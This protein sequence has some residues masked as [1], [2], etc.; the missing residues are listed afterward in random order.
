MAEFGFRCRCRARSPRRSSATLQVGALSD[1]A[2]TVVSNGVQLLAAVLA[3]AGCAVASF[4]AEGQRRRAWL[5]LKEGTGSWAAGQVVWS[6]YE[7]W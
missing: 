2:V 1:F 4:R 5:W 6:F 7:V 3:S